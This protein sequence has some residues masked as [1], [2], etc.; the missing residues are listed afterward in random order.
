MEL[1]SML[2]G[3]KAEKTEDQTVEEVEVD[4]HEENVKSE[5]PD[6]PKE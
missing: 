6:K 5:K 4:D 2:Q 3:A 1:P